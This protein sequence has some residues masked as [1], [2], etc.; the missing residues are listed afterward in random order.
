MLSKEYRL[1]S[2]SQLKNSSFFK[3]PLFA[4]KI[5]KNG[6]TE[7]RFAFLVRKKVDKRAVKRN[8]IRRVFRSCI[9]QMHAEIKPGYDMLFFL[10]KSIIEQERD[11]LFK[12]LQK[13]LSEK[14]FLTR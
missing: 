6:I 7:S 10:E 9:E 13:F 2:N 1:P 12:E 3:T 11:T 4:V 14:G 8:K 5:A